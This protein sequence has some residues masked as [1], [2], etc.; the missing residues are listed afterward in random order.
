MFEFVEVL[1]DERHQAFTWMFWLLVAMATR[2]KAQ[3][4]FGLRHI[5][6]IF[7]IEITWDN[8]HQPLTSLLWYFS[9]HGNQS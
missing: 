3:N 4:S 9:C 1:W 6:F 5:E 7:G 8:R 2:V